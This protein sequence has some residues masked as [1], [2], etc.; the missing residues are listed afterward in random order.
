MIKKLS[1]IYLLGALA[2]T[3]CV[4]DEGNNIIVDENELK[5]QLNEANIEGID[6]SYYKVADVENLDIPVKV[7]GT[8][9]GDDLSGFDFEW[10]ICSKDIGN[11][12]HTHTVI[13]HDRDLSYSLNGVTPGSYTIYFRATDKATKLIYEKSCYLNVISPYVRGFYLYGD[14]ED[15]TVGIDFVSMLDERDTTVIADMFDNTKGIKHAK[16][17]VFTG[18]T[19]MGEAK[20]NLEYLYAVT[21]DNSYSLTHTSTES[22]IGFSAADINELAWPTISTVKKPFKVLD[23]L[24]HAYGPGNMMRSRTA[25]YVMTDQAMFFGSLYQAESYG[26]PA[27]CYVQGDEKLVQMSPYGFYPNNSSYTSAVYLFDRTNHKFVKLSSTYSSNTNLA[28]VTET[29]QGAFWLDQSK[30]TPVRDLVYGENGKGNNGASY[31]LMKDTDGKYYVYIFRAV[32]SYS[33]VKMAA[34][35]INLDVATDFAKASHYAFYSNQYIVLYSVGNDLWAYNY[36][37]N[38]AQKVKSFD[39]EITYLAF[40]V[41]SDGNADDII[42]ATWSPSAKGTVYKYEVEDSPNDLKINEKNYA[43]KSYPWKTGLKVVKVEY[44]NCKE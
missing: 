17:L 36:N 18:C 9:S 15:G 29:S 24:P 33:F 20:A 38:K 37:S 27:N 30:Y 3:S 22:K 40:D 1:I 11:T 14:K 25:R 23:I 31:A 34:K 6:D 4:E 43:T 19:G 39:G 16:D 28:S 2:L 12:K 35:N 32:S 5:S 41:H 42:V 10:Y 21:D 7:T 44:R 13:S 8:L 26:N